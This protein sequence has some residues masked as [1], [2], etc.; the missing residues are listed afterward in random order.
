ML[1]AVEGGGF[2][3]SSA[4]GYSHGL[5]LLLLGRKEEEKPVKVS[6]WNQYGLVDGK[7]S[8]YH[9]AS[10]KIKLPRM[11]SLRLLRSTA[12]EL[13]GVYPAKLSSSNSL[14][15]LEEPS[16][17][18]EKKVTANGSI[19]G[20]ERKGCLKSNSK[21][22]WSILYWRVKVKNHVSHWKRCKP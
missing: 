13:E 18:T 3:S 7:L 22:I 5:A 20:D 4:S 12:S 8:M 9:L 21:G 19:T 2:F 17:S 6:P 11:C 1:L 16:R 15:S 10:T 14:D